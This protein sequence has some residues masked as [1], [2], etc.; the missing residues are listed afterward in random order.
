[1][2]DWIKFCFIEMKQK[3]PE[4]IVLYREGLTEKQ[5]D[6]QGRAEI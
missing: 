5:F 6:S 2:I 3:M 4:V 1:M